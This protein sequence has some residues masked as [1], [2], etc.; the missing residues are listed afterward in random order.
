V[1]R[2]AADAGMHLVAGLP[3]GAGDR[4]ASGRAAAAGVSA[5]P[6]RPTIFRPLR[7]P[8]YCWDN[9]RQI[10]VRFRKEPED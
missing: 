3:A 9:R 10:A 7:A 1:V 5:P 6:Y 4:E 2:S 8:V